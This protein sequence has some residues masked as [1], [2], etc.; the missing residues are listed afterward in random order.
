MDRD[1]EI[2]ALALARDAAEAAGLRLELVRGHDEHLWLLFSG[3]QLLL[4]FRPV[5]RL[6]QRPDVS[7]PVKCADVWRAIDLALRIPTGCT[8][9]RLH[10]RPPTR[11]YST[12]SSIASSRERR[13]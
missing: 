9:P 3:T 4:T 6:A 11:S 13:C 7:P 12:S 1:D 5:R 8:E 2:E 10:S